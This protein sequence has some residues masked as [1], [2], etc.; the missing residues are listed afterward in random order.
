MRVANLLLC[1]VLVSFVGADCGNKEPKVLAPTR[2]IVPDGAV[3]SLR[4]GPPKDLAVPDELRGVAAQFFHP[5]TRDPFTVSANAFYD[6]LEPTTKN[7]LPQG[8]YRFWRSFGETFVG[9]GSDGIRVA[10][11]N[12]P[13]SHPVAAQAAN[14][15]AFEGTRARNAD[16]WIALSDRPVAP[17]TMG[18]LRIRGTS[19]QVFPN[20]VGP[21]PRIAA[22]DIAVA[23]LDDDRLALAW[24]DPG[25]TGLTV[26]LSFFDASAASFSV[27]IAADTAP[28]DAAAMELAGRTGTELQLVGLVDR[29]AVVWRPLVP[30]GPVDPGSPSAPPS[31]AVRAE[32]RIAIADG[33]TAPTVQRHGTWA[34]PLGGTS[35]IGPWPLARAGLVATRLGETAAIAWNDV[36]GTGARVLAVSAKAGEAPK[37]VTS[38]VY[39]LQFRTTTTGTD[40][41]MYAPNGAVRAASVEY[42]F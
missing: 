21:R 42:T 40:L 33:K 8:M 25:P 6:P 18:L 2:D 3:L 32:I 5:G 36:S 16:I 15:G 17:T 1:A 41:L 10:Q 22:G 7:P 34:T 19:G 29:V 31:R 37:E 4:V 39:R 38:L 24:V 14:L 28:M 20:P 9:Y 11:R 35:G 26:L 23:A 30:D 13:T 12:E 27:P